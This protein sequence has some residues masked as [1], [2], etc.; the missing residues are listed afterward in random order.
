MKSINIRKCQPFIVVAQCRLTATWVQA[1]NSVGQVCKS[2][3]I[4]AT[5][6]GEY[7]ANQQ[8]EFTKP[9]IYWLKHQPVRTG[10]NSGMSQ[11]LLETH[12]TAG[13]YYHSTPGKSGLIFYVD[14]HI[15]VAGFCWMWITARGQSSE[16]IMYF[17]GDTSGVSCCCRSIRPTCTSLKTANT[18]G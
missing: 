9:D 16:Q 4:K 7:T 18:S 10:R 12:T 1:H 11:S 8:M 3:F 14:H 6:H 15:T 5:A 2:Q 17:H 13:V